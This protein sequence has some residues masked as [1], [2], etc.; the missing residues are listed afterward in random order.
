M[1]A[2][3]AV[4]VRH[5]FRYLARFSAFW[6]LLILCLAVLPAALFTWYSHNQEILQSVK[7][8][9]LHLANELQE[10][11]ENAGEMIRLHERYWLPGGIDDT[12]LYKKGIYKTHSESIDLVNQQKIDTTDR[13][14]YEEFYFDIAN[15]ISNTYYDPYSYPPLRDASSDRSWFWNLNGNM[16]FTYALPSDTLRAGGARFLQIVSSMPARYQVLKFNVKGLIMLLVIFLLLGGLYR[17]IQRLSERLFLRKYFLGERPD[18]AAGLKKLITGYRTIAIADDKYIAALLQLPHEYDDPL[19][20]A[21]KDMYLY[22]QR[23]IKTISSYKSFYNYVWR[24][25]NDRQ[26]YLLYQF[27]RHGLING[28][29]TGDIYALMNKGILFIDARHE[30]I[31]LMSRSFRGYILNELPADKVEAFSQQN[32]SG[33]TWRSLRV[34]FLLVLMLIASFI[35]FTQHDAW[36]R[37]IALI[38]GFGSIFP[39]LLNIFNAAGKGDSK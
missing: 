8:Q 25:C 33:S 10:R 9:Q 20:I 28:R 26:K 34:P 38:T 14:S 27:A 6:M 29:N 13:K 37:I 4:E 2:A 30:E 3:P 18:S 24:Q 35:F 15:R 31:Q 5:P 21:K 22:E 19:P 23:L 7:K 11:K 36:Q 32:K 12:L 16:T 1:P 17:L 39:L